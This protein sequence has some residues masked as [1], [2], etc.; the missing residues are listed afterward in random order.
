MLSLRAENDTMER[1][2]L[3]RCLK[4]IREN[5]YVNVNAK[6]ILFSWIHSKILCTFQILGILSNYRSSSDDRR[7][8]GE[9]EMCTLELNNS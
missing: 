7:E 6:S 2:P 8:P 4:K 9:D 3:D 5:L 1:I